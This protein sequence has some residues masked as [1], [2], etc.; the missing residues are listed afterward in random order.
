[1]C[2]F[3]YLHSDFHLNLMIYSTY[4]CF[5][6]SEENSDCSTVKGAGWTAISFFDNDDDDDFSV[7]PIDQPGHG[8]F[9]YF[10][11]LLCKWHFDSTKYYYYLF[12][13]KKDFYMHHQDYSACSCNDHIQ[14]DFTT[15]GSRFGHSQYICGHET[16]YDPG[17]INKSCKDGISTCLPYHVGKF[18]I[19]KYIV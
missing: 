17:D 9:D 4:S 5:S 6:T 18:A 2:I 16:Y 13:Y 3:N 8:A 12:L 14:V 7:A 19:Y 11:D 1:M 10:N 15:P